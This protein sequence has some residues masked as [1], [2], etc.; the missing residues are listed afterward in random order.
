MG[1]TDPTEQNAFRASIS[2]MKHA[3]TFLGFEGYSTVRVADA[4]S[5]LLA[6]RLA[7]TRHR[8]HGQQNRQHGL[9]RFRALCAD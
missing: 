4:H 1:P 5:R 8:Q 2:V 7:H 6:T 9:Q 3:F